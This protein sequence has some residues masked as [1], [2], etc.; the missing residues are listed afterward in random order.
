MYYKLF[1][2]E[3]LDEWDKSDRII[4]ED[5]I[6]L[7]FCK[8]KKR[9]SQHKKVRYYFTT[10][11][12]LSLKAWLL[13]LKKLHLCFS[14]AFKL[15]TAFFPGWSHRSSIW[16]FCDKRNNKHHATM[17]WIML[18]YFRHDLMFVIYDENVTSSKKIL[19]QSRLFL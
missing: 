5:R 13:P 1:L 16:E 4:I 11:C 10:A 12:Y 17:G 18:V 15:F 6:K 7:Y 3:C 2:C 9:K 19:Y 14:T 8:V